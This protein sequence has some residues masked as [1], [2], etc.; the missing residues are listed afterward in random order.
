MI[1]LQELIEKLRPEIVGLS[2]RARFQDGW[3]D[4]DETATYASAS[5]ITVAVDV[6][7]MFPTGCRVRIKQDSGTWKYYIVT[8]SSVAVDDV[9]TINLTGGSDYT[10]ANETIT[11]IQVSY[12]TG[13]QPGW[14]GWFNYAP[15]ETGWTSLTANVARFCPEGRKMTVVLRVTG[16]S[17]ATG[18]QI[19]LP[20][21]AATVYGTSSSWSGALGYSQDNGTALSAAGCWAI[22]SGGSV[23]VC[24]KT[25]DLGNWTN[26]GTKLILV[27]AVY[28]F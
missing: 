3:L 8:S 6:R 15:T 12:M 5:S 2:R 28:E 23:V 19:S 7:A 24:Y 10:V 25:F 16:T 13:A 20:V 11:R 14:P 27:Q 17:D 26:S 9:A 1:N 18:A 22:V 21:A 4:I